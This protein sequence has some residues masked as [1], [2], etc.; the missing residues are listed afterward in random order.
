MPIERIS[1]DAH[2]YWMKYACATSKIGLGVLW[3]KAGSSH[4]ITVT[5]R[6]RLLQAFSQGVGSVGDDWRPKGRRRSTSRC[7]SILSTQGPVI[8]WIGHRRQACFRLTLATGVL[9]PGCDITKPMQF[10]VMHRPMLG[11]DTHADATAASRYV[12]ESSAKMSLLLHV[13]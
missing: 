8:G 10:G 6:A 3:C 12:K 11:Q 1:S 5:L 4:P 2:G 7:L 9:R 13:S